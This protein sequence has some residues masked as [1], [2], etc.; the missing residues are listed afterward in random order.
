VKSTKN[1]EDVLENKSKIE[2]L[3]LEELLW[4]HVH[5]DLNFPKNVKI[6]SNLPNLQEDV[7]EDITDVQEDVWEEHAQLVQ[8]PLVQEE[9]LKLF[10]LKDIKEDVENFTVEDTEEVAEDWEEVKEEKENKK[11]L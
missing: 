2:K 1:A 4:K 9:Q 3:Y 11:L 7:Q 6:V 10:V 5:V 8:K